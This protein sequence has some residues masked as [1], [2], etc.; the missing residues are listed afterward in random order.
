MKNVPICRTSEEWALTGSNRRPPA[1]R[2]GAEQ[3]AR[4][5]DDADSAHRNSVFTGS[6]LSSL[7]AR[8]AAVSAPMFVACSMGLLAGWGSVA[9]TAAPC[10]K[11]T[12]PAKTACVKQAKRDAMAYPP[13]PSWREAVRR[14]SAY[15]LATAQRVSGCEE[16]GSEHGTGKG[17][18]PWARRWSL[19]GGSGSYVSGFGMAH[20]T[21]GIGARITGYPYPPQASPAQQLL[22]AVAGAHSFGWSGWG[23]F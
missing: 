10:A 6:T 9:A 14:V 16:P 21:Y 12:G 20:S 19:S 1:C 2:S 7:R 18:S 5:H 15:D 3:F 11:H 4:V 8:F 17:A 13:N 22:V 23:C